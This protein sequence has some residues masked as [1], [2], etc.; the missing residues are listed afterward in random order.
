MSFAELKTLLGKNFFF[1]IIDT[2][3][4]LSR[5]SYVGFSVTA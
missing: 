1:A 4:Y 2:R 5:E 3:P